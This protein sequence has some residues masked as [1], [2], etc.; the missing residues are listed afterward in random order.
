MSNKNIFATLDNE[1][2]SNESTLNHT[3][4]SWGDATDEDPIDMPI[5]LQSERVIPNRSD[6]L[7]NVSVD[8]DMLKRYNDELSKKHTIEVSHNVKIFDKQNKEVRVGQNIRTLNVVS[9]STYDSIKNTISRF[10]PFK[11]S[12]YG[13]NFIDYKEQ[14]DKILLAN[15]LMKMCYKDPKVLSRFVYPVIVMQLDN[16]KTVLKNEMYYD[17]KT[18]KCSKNDFSISDNVVTFT[19]PKKE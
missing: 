9:K 8:N 3:S 19:P 12:T 4:L 7:D 5:N 18:K 17:Y 15:S 11:K 1:D 14:T 10:R 16:G 2:S 6:E 13:K